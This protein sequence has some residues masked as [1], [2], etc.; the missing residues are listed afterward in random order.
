MGKDA[1]RLQ[2]PTTAFDYVELAPGGV[3]SAPSA[4][5]CEDGYVLLGGQVD[6]CP[7]DEPIASLQERA[8]LRCGAAAHASPSLGNPGEG[9]ARLLF[10]RVATES[11]GDVSAA[12]DAADVA[13]LTWREA[14]HGG[15][16]RIATRH[17]WG[18]DD[19][20]SSWTFLDH[21]VLASHSS[22][23]YHYHD[24]L[25]EWFVVLAGSGQM[26]I[27]DHTFEVS[28]GSVTFQGIGEAHG[29]YNPN[30]DE[31]LD[32]LRIA[33]A[34]PGK[35]VTSIDLHDDLVSPSSSHNRG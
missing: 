8:V 19:F 2:T 33:V 15:A 35:T 24:A 7:G 22:V 30:P 9:T 12:T 17:I 32:F 4:I 28:A 23:G 14:I 27:A 20:A 1:G 10:V 18:P 6:V 31:E 34:V 3:F 29:I 11:A 13:L 16:G 5:P 21:A 26:T 25:E